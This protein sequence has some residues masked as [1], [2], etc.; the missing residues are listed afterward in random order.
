GA[1]VGA[2]S[3]SLLLAFTGTAEAGTIPSGLT[4]AGYDL[5]GLTREEAAQK[6]EEHFDLMAAQTVTLVV[7]ENQVEAAAGD[8]G[9]TWVNEEA[10][11][12]ELNLAAG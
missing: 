4:V 2:L 5:T 6:L 10:V 11:R 9:L 8:L 1:G 3:F 12:E 7:G